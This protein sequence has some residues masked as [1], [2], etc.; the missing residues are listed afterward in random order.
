MHRLTLALLSVL[1][2]FV[3]LAQ[4]TE[5]APADAAWSVVAELAGREAPESLSPTARFIWRGRRGIELA[6]VATEFCRRFH[7]DPR[8]WQAI[9]WMIER[10]PLFIATPEHDWPSLDLP[11]PQFMRQVKLDPERAQASRTRLAELRRLLRES[12]D[13]PEEFK[14]RL[15]RSELESRLYADPADPAKRRALLDAIEQHSRRFPADEA[16]TSLYTRLLSIVRYAAPEQEAAF[17]RELAASEVSAARTVAAE[18]ERVRAMLAKPLDLAFT[19]VDGREV[20]LA[21]LRGKVVL[22]DFWATWCG[23]CIAEIPNVKR[24]YAEYHERGFEIIGVS[25]DRTQDRQKLLDFVTRQNMP[26]P[27]HFDGKGGRNE[28]AVRFAVTSIPAM[29]LVDPTGRVVSTNARGEKLAAEVKRLL[30]P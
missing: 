27:Q 18:E 7:D 8:R 15:A 2:P 16:V 21:K 25:L 24:V 12:A 28:L 26:W 23:P 10:P 5:P 17:L 9:Y 6:D 3:T 4:A 22:I 13:A 29:L 20:D 30:T 19:A 11:V 1:W 14:M